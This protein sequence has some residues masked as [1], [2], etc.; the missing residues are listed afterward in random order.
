MEGG[1]CGLKED[2]GWNYLTSCRIDYKYA[3]FRYMYLLYVV[4]FKIQERERGGI[5]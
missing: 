3:K 1:R 4:G 2:V 5:F